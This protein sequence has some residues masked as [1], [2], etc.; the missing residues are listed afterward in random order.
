MVE[1]TSSG[2][3]KMSLGDLKEF[4]AE[5]DAAGASNSTPIAGRVAF[6]GGLKALKA[7][8]IRVGDEVARKDEPRI[9][10]LP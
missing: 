5:M 3:R 2:G 7:V 10:R 6:G 4:V 9:P 1:M 8:A